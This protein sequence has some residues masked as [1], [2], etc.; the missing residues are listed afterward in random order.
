[1]AA[2]D[3]AGP[4]PAPLR[5]AVAGPRPRRLRRDPGPRRDRPFQRARGVTAPAPDRSPRDRVGR[6]LTGESGRA[7]L[8]PFNPHGTFH[9]EVTMTRRTLAQ[10]AA[11]AG[12]LAGCGG[13]GSS[14]PLTESDFCSQK[15]DAECQ[16]TDQCVTEKDACK[17]KRMTTCTAFVAQAKASGKRVFVPGNIGNCINKT[18]NVYAK[19]TEITPSEMADVNDACNYVFQGDGEVNVDMCDVKYDCK[20]KVICDKGFCAMSK[21][22]TTTCGNPGDICPTGQYCAA[23]ASNIMVCMPKGA[24]G[25]TCSATAP[26][27][28]DLRCAESKCTERV[29]MA[30]ACTS[31]DDCSSVAPFCDPYAGNKCDKGL[32]FS[33][34]ST[35]CGDFGGTSSTG[36]AGNGGGTA[37]T[38]GGAVGA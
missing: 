34:G 10:L 25:D 8:R 22:V 30:G 24:S 3:H 27:T 31:N 4:R 35:S 15:A 26:C 32:S 11:I 36:T 17:A 19:T 18:K 6:P 23:N 20:D 29:G 13:G 9:P 21:N 5:R 37:G 16:V 28:E 7:K 38:G 2:R 33:A 12:L 14:K 1:M